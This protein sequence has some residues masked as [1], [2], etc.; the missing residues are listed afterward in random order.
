MKF[1]ASL[2]KLWAFLNG[3]EKQTEEEKLLERIR[4]LKKRRKSLEAALKSEAQVE[5][6]FEK[7]NKELKNI[8]DSFPRGSWYAFSKFLLMCVILYIILFNVINL[9]YTEIL[10]V[11]ELWG[12]I[13]TWHTN[14]YLL[15]YRPISWRAYKFC[16]LLTTWNWYLLI[17][18]IFPIL[19]WV[20]QSLLIRPHARRLLQ[21][22]SIIVFLLWIFLFFSSFGILMGPLIIPV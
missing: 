11:M 22:L 4:V 13:E 7:V 5:G 1:R 3:D 8:L 16:Y 15:R 2:K 19:L 6:E 9:F 18:V 17:P 14:W 20:I 21:Y 10:L 12:P